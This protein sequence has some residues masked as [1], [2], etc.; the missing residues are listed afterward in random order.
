MMTKHARV[1]IFPLLPPA[2]Q[3]YIQQEDNVHRPEP[4][5]P[6]LLKAATD[7]EALPCRDSRDLEY[8]GGFELPQPRAVQALEACLSIRTPGYNVYVAGDANFG[9]TFMVREFLAPRAARAE[10]P[11]DIVYLHDFRDPDRPRAVSLPPGQG[12]RLKAELAK[13]VSALLKEVPLRLEEESLAGERDAV[14][15]S[16]RQ[17]RDSLMREMESDAERRGF[18]VS[19]DNEGQFSL[20]PMVRGRPVSESDL[21]DLEPEEREDLRK[22]AEGLMRSLNGV[23]RSI[24]RAERGLKES[25]RE[26]DRRAMQ[27]CLAEILD[28]L[29]GEY[30]DRTEL[31]DWFQE[32][33]ADML[34]NMERFLPQEE[35]RGREQG[36]ESA[37]DPLAR[38]EVN[39]FISN[40]NTRGAPVVLCDHPTPANLLGCAERQAELGALYTDHTLVKAGDLHRA[41]GG[42]L[43]LRMEDVRQ[44]PEAWDGL[45]R[46][47]L[48]GKARIEDL[49]EQDQTRT[50]TVEPEPVP[51][52]LKVVLVGTDEDY[53]T[54]LY[55]EDRFIKLFKLKAH[56]QG[57]MPRNDNAVKYLLGQLARIIRDEDLPPFDRGALAGMVDFASRDAED[58]QRLSLYM[59][60]MR[61]LMIEAGSLA[62][63]DSRELIDR[64]CLD[65]AVA[66]RIFRANLYEEEFLQDYDRQLIKV[67]TSGSAVGRA[68]GLSVTLLGD[69]EF[70]LPHQIACAAGVGHGGILDLEREAELGGPIHTKGMMIIKSYLLELF[71]QDKPLTLTGSLCFE[72]SYAE[73][74]GDSASGAEL[75]ALLSA[76]SGAPIDLSLAV[77]GAVSQSGAFL[78]VGGVNPKIEGFFRVCKR[79]G[80]N[81]SQ[82]VVIPRDNVQHL[83][84]SDEVVEAVA[85]GEFHI[86]PVENIEKAMEVLT[87]VPAG[88]R[89]ED[90]KYPEGTLYR[91][92][93]DRLAELAKLADYDGRGRKDGK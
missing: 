1:G 42:F 15:Q 16:F 81:G 46:S 38:Y 88:E 93:D 54:L 60:L 39:L 40:E 92:I 29:C 28:P 61:E 9:R 67:R 13:A 17:K 4:L 64:E 90:G 80:L 45:L 72:Q 30:S 89:G 55:H 24:G 49:G 69:Y 34:E 5:S 26:L 32:M 85:A 23:L 14:R 6:D 84:L 82:G 86:Y 10:T 31:R 44:Q 75:A 79:R 36:H 53:E 41:N 50:K 73:V 65:R 76:L 58:Q 22:R 87:G 70:G 20:F 37:E 62:R 52:D 78:S 91:R 68:N 8:D 12:R 2:G 11:P 56:L 25:E 66:E 74:E 18:D 43:I 3:Y 77:T 63:A 47:L 48:A 71:A 83:M 33:R 51:L 57:A 19:M 35:P 27:T 7:P 59:P 21:V